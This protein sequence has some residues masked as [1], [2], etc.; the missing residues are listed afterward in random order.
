MQLGE[1]GHLTYCTNIHAGEPLDEVMAS[2]AKHLPGIRAGI[3]TGHPIGVGLRL[4]H[5]AAEAL[6]DKSALAALK[7][8]L[9]E[10]NYYVFTINGFPYGPFHGRTVKEEVYKPD[11]SDP[12]RLAYT[13]HLADILSELL[14]EGE[15]GS[16]ST[17]P[18]T[19]KPW[20]ENRLSAITEHL[21]RHVAHLVSIAK[22]KG[23]TIALALEPEPCCYLE[24]IEE[25]VVFFNEHL[26][27]RASLARL[28]ALSGLGAAQ[29]ESAMRR[30]IGVCYDVCH[31]AVEFEDPKASVDRLRAN[32]ILV[33]KLQLSSALK[34]AA[35]DRDSAKHLAAFAEPVY[36]HQVVQKADGRLRRFVDLPQALAE[37]ERARGAEWRVHFHVPVFL[38]QMEHFGTTQSFLSEILRLHRAKPISRHLE[39][40]TYTWDVLPAAYRSVELSAAI[41]R[42]LN[43][44]KGQ[45]GR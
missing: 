18:S 14:P 25:A 28:A 16:V 20:A 41:A 15:E 26:F 45:L 38:E 3:G 5:A 33:A 29:A 22:E 17:V 31:A 40:E 44:V 9:A 6:R 43:W 32:A 11:W 7:R 39:V 30:H 34:I 36:L 21:I 1:L 12:H 19:F 4:G 23:K 37:A 42:E 8:F 24:T 13:D 10:G 27:N 2:L 35:V